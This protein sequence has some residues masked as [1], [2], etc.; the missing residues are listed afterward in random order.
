M[1]YLDQ[2]TLSILKS[3]ITRITNTF[4]SDYD[5]KK[6]FCPEKEKLTLDK[7]KHQDDVILKNKQ[8]NKQ[9]NRTTSK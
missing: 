8:I 3:E 1:R 4:V 2:R 7:Q 5:V 9:V 6:T